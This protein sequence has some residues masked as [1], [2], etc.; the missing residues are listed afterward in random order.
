MMQPT[1]RYSQNASNSDDS[2]PRQPWPPQR[3]IAWLHVFARVP[4]S[5]GAVAAAMTTMDQREQEAA[6]SPEASADDRT[7][8]RQRKVSLESAATGGLS[9]LRRS[10]SQPLFVLLAMVAVLLAIACGNV[11]GLLL[12]RAA[13]RQREMA[14][15][16]SIG[17]GRSRL[18]RQMLAE[19]LLLAVAGGLLG[20]TFAVWARDALLAL[21]VNV[22]SSS[23]PIDLNTGLDWRV[24]GFALAVSTITG[25]ACGV[26]PAV[27][28]TRGAVADSLKEQGRG[29]VTEGGRRG[30]LVGKALVA[31]QMAFCLLLLVVA[32][33]FTRSLRSLTQTD[34]GFDRDHILTARVDVRGA[35]YSDEERRSLYE[36]LT[37]RIEALPGVRSASLSARGPLSN[38]ARISSLS[39]EGYTPAPKEQ[40]RTNE[41]VVTGSTSTRSASA[42]SKAAVSRPRIAWRARAPPSSTRRSR[43]ASS[44]APARSAS[45]GITV[46]RSARSRTSSSASSRTHA[47]WTCGGNRRTWPTGS[48]TRRRMT[49]C[50]DIEVLTSGAPGALAQTL[51]ETIAQAEPRLPIVEV[52]PLADRISRGVAQDRMVARL[53]TMFGGLA[54]LL[55]SLGLYGTISYGI[56]RRVAELGL[57]MALGA[58]RAMVLWMVL[59]EALALVVAG[60]V[61]GLPMAWAAGQSMSAL[62]YNV[63]AGDPL[64]FAIGAVTLVV[65]AALAAYLPAHRASRIEPMVALGR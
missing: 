30:L 64:S 8:I 19:S 31:I 56:S 59:R 41:E 39:V 1:I 58:D 23:A 49:C 27:R 29:S 43:N 3:N 32:G 35:G 36:R 40:L 52:T 11:A 45:G 7:A 25:L 13:G 37:A 61:I 65:V 4:S 26:L 6:L 50:R 55:A 34:V 20:I 57:R 17:A 16:Q 44:A 47:T 38:S 46:G 54:L 12:A 14:I 15:R 9:S 28:G 42:S 5:T 62:L 10:A 51:R 2:D 63:G 18:V 48:R 53:T 33:L 21:M 22:G 24:M 60:A